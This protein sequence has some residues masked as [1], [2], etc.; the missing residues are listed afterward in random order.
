MLRDQQNFTH[1]NIKLKSVELEKSTASNY[2][3][4][5][6]TKTEKLNEIQSR[7][8]NQANIFIKKPPTS[9][10]QQKRTV[11]GQNSR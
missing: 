11:F 9:D 7:F 6:K 3:L 2:E 4:E 5:R 10:Q 8:S 1:D